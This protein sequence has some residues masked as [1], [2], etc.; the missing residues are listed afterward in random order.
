MATTFVDRVAVEALK[1]RPFRVLLWVLAA[2]FYVIGFLLGLLLIIG[3]W[4][5]GAV[6][7]GIDEVRARAPRAL[8]PPGGD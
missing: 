7:A 4:S 2:P 3:I 6:K 1:I 5:L 8:P